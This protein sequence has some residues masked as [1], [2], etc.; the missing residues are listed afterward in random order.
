MCL[1]STNALGCKN[2]TL[3][4]RTLTRRAYASDGSIRK[5]ALTE[6]DDY[7]CAAKER[8]EKEREELSKVAGLL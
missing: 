3:V 2:T 6:R 5:S 7:Y 4:A 1:P 8:K